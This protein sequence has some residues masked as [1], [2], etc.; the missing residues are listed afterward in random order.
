[1]LTFLELYRGKPV[2]WDQRHHKSY[3]KCTNHTG[4]ELAKAVGI[5]VDDCKKKM[6]SLLSSLRR[7]NED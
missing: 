7:C 2:L 4:E 3:Y 5:P 6:N 1:M